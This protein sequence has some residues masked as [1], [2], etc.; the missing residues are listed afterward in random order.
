MGFNSSFMILN[1]RLHDIEHDAKFGQKLARAIGEHQATSVY[2]PTT[3]AYQSQVLSVQ[4]AD[5]KAVVAVGGNTGFMVGMGL[6][7]F[8]SREN[9]SVEDRYPRFGMPQDGWDRVA[10]LRQLADECGFTLRKKP[11]RKC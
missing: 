2:E 9:D 4:H 7:S 6:G 11:Q 3:F 5:I 1:D 8:Y 10:L